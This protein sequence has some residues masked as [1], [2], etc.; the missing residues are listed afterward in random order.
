MNLGSRRRPIV[1][2]PLIFGF[3]SSLVPVVGLYWP[4]DDVAVSGKLDRF[5]RVF[6]S[7]SRSEDATDNATAPLRP[8][9]KLAALTMSIAAVVFSEG[10]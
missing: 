4:H 10:A 1:S 9:E 6:R 8:S 5:H 3:V 2:V 7:R